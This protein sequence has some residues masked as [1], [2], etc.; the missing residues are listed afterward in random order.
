M[1]LD[2][3]LHYFDYQFSTVNFG[4]NI[5]K[6][7]LHV[8]SLKSL[9]FMFLNLQKFPLHRLTI[10]CKNKEYEMI[11]QAL[12]SNNSSIS[13][14]NSGLHIYFF[15]TLKLLHFIITD[16]EVKKDSS[17]QIFVLVINNKL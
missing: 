11:L 5:Q 4:S 9:N 12:V 10:F 3:Y 13:Q 16:A 8:V 7:E 17:Y 2:V 14:V 15:K 1:S 6:I